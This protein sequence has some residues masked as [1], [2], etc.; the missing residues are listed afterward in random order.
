MLIQAT[1]KFTYKKISLFSN[2][3]FFKN[4]VKYF[5]DFVLQIIFFILEVRTDHETTVF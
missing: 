3:K 1:Y 2:T 5:F 4:L